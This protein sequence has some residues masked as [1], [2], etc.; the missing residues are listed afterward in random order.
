MDSQLRAFRDN[1][2]PFRAPHFP[3]STAQ[4]AYF[5][6]ETIGLTFWTPLFLDF[7]MT[8]KAP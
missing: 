4:A 3:H 7:L 2:F 5:P 8:P 1:L 6:R